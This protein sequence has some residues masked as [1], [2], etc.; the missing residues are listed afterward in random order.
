MRLAF[1]WS[2]DICSHEKIV[3]PSILV[4]IDQTIGFRG[5]AIERIHAEIPHTTG[6]LIG[7]PSAGEQ[8]PLTAC[9]FVHVSRK[10][11]PVLDVKQSASVGLGDGSLTVQLEHNHAGI[12]AHGQQIARLMCCDHPKAI[13]FSSVRVDSCALRQVPHT[14]GPVLRVGQNQITLRVKNH[15]RDIA[16]VPPQ[17]VHLPCLRIVPAPDLDEAIVSTRCN[18]ILLRVKRSPID[19]TVVPLQDMLDNRIRGAENVR[20]TA[21]STR[22]GSSRNCFLPQP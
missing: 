16:E 21:P 3:C 5:T 14:D 15:A 6:H 22:R 20:S 11:L 17:R 19:P 2:A 13:I 1:V 9:S 4:V 12:M 18:Q 7:S 10:D 8:H